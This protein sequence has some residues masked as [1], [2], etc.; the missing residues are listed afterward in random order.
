MT[1]LDN[2]LLGAYAPGGRAVWCP[3]CSRPVARAG[4]TIE[5]ARPLELLKRFKL[6]DHARR[7]R[8]HALRRPAQAAGDGPGADGEPDMIMLDE[9]MAGVNPALVQSLLDHVQGLRDVGHDRAVRRARHGRGDVDLRLGRRAWPRARD[10]RGAARRRV[11]NP[12]GD[13][14][15]PRLHPRRARVREDD[16][17]CAEAAAPLLDAS[18]LVAGYLPGVDILNGCS[19]TSAPARSSASSGPTAP[20]SRRW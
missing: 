9:P 6:V 8:R 13:R 14:R 5:V 17:G 19:L 7:L 11:A 4:A 2:M 15:L 16:V 18:D 20:A 1:V 3:R 10:R 12:A